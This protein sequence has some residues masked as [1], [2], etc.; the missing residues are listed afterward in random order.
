M[1][2]LGQ[3]VDLS[4]LEERSSFDPIPVGQY[5]VGI[6][7]ADL[8]PCKD[9]SNKMVVIE[10]MVKGGDYA[11]RLLWARL[12]IINSN[13]TA[14]ELAWKELGELGRAIGL[15]TVNDT[16][17]F[18]GR[19]CYLDVAIEPAKGE[20]GPSNRIKKYHSL[21][22]GGHAVPAASSTGAAPAAKKPWEQ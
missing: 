21:S 19:E 12:N 9:P 1:A 17:Q 8:K 5:H 10:F 7:K 18:P 3:N 11:D 13:P 16:D 4:T 2:S 20:Y 14:Q 6:S 22:S 15:T